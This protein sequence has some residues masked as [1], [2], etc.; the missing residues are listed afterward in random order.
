MR[1]FMIIKD[2]EVAKLLADEVRRS[3]LH[4]LRHFEMT[5]CQLAKLLNKSV[6][7]II[8]HLNALEKAGLVEQTRSVVKGNLVERYYRA[9]AKIF[10]I[11][12]VLSEGLVPGSEEIA[13]WTREICKNAVRGLEAFG[14]KLGE[15]D[16]EELLNLV[17]RYS[18]L[19][20]AA[21]E[22]AIS[23]YSS[24]MQIDKSALKLILSLLTDLRLYNNREF[25]EVL[26]RI[27]R[28]LEG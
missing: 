22:E 15:K 7:S 3:I 16:A 20:Q 12:Y 1:E 25:L 8:H 17:E 26:N 28:K 27:Q 2:P 9:S 4:N 13:Q 23:K 6:S 11:S 24:P 10:I 18:H 14:F 19:E 5:P 21:R